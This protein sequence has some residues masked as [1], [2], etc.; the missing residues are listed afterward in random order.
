MVR[1]D[2]DMV[3]ADVEMVRADTQVHPYGISNFQIIPFPHH[4][5][6][7]GWGEGKIKQKSKF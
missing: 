2:M 4:G 5:T 6:L 7:W 1:A 3:R